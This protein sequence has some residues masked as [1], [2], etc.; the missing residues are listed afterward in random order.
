MVQPQAEA[1]GVSLADL[2]AR[3]ELLPA[4]QGS[5]HVLSAGFARQLQRGVSTVSFSDQRDEFSAAD[6]TFIAF[7]SW[8]P[9]AR[10]KGSLILRIVDSG[11]RTVLQSKPGKLDLRPGVPIV[12]K[13]NVPIPTTPGWYRADFL[14]DGKPAYRAFVKISG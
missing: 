8:N 2:R 9:Q 12:S 3:G 7:V 14:L 6:K 11:N 10:I 1:V 4:L 5:E 13:W